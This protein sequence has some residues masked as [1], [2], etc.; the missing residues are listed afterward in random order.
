MFGRL[1]TAGHSTPDCVMARELFVQLVQT[2]I[3]FQRNALLLHCELHSPWFCLIDARDAGG[4]C[5]GASHALALMKKLCR[6]FRTTT[7]KQTLNT[8]C[9]VI[10]IYV[11]ISSTIDAEGYISGPHASTPKSIMLQL[12]RVVEAAAKIT[13]NTMNYDRQSADAMITFHI[14]PPDAI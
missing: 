12:H 7:K 6:P 10:Y 13:S 1:A 14:G 5:C 11:Y 8:L 3:V 2:F 4:L 9:L